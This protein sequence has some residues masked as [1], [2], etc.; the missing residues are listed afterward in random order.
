MSRI[1]NHNQPTQRTLDTWRYHPA[2]HNPNADNNSHMQHNMRL[3][4]DLLT[5]LNR[6]AASNRQ[7]TSSILT[8]E[9]SM[10]HRR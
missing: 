1:V 9:R 8:S 3:K 10:L 7:P 2:V 5:A 4:N 6:N